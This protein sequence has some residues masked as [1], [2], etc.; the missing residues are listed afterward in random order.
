LI[1]EIR[2]SGTVILKQA[3][4]GRRGHLWEGARVVFIETGK[5]TVKFDYW[6]DGSVI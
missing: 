2:A 5:L 3:G 6:L 1:V 4:A